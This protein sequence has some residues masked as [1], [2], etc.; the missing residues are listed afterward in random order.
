[1][2]VSLRPVIEKCGE[3]YTY[4]IDHGVVVNLMREV[5]ARGRLKPGS[6]SRTERDFPFLI[7]VPFSEWPTIRPPVPINTAALLGSDGLILPR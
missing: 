7:S 6:N 2:S 5:A 3:P 4:S 1:M